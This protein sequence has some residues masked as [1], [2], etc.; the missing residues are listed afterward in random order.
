[1][2]APVSSKKPE[3]FTQP[4]F[5]RIGSNAVQSFLTDTAGVYV[6]KLPFIR[7]GLQLFEDTY[8]EGV[9][10]AAFY[11]TIPTVSDHVFAPLLSNAVDLKGK[12]L[13]SA[14]SVKD[15]VGTPI[16]KLG[17]VLN[18]LPEA[19]ARKLIGAK[20]GTV[21]GSLGVA[22]GFEY[23]IQHTKNWISADVF[24]AKN[25]T[26]VAGLEDRQNKL[27]E[28]QHDPV[29]KAKRRFKQVGAAVAGTTLG[30]LAVAKGVQNGVIPTTVAKNSLKWMDFGNVFDLSKPLQAALVGV[31]VVSYLDAARDKLE[32]KETATRLGMVVPY[33][34]VGKELSRNALAWGLERVKLPTEKVAIHQLKN[35]DGSRFSFFDAKPKNPFAAETFLNFDRVKSTIAP[36][37][38]KLAI[39]PESKQLINRL[40]K[41]IGTGQYLLSAVGMTAFVCLLTYSQTRQRYK[42]QQEALQNTL[43]AKA[44]VVKANNSPFGAFQ[45]HA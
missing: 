40:Y 22:A 37:V 28:G 17:P 1:M 18:A 29:A 35:A 7:S 6:P 11:F 3:Q 8:L 38:E 10:D 19:E 9:E 25:F 20:A 14:A 2:T 42:Q 41:G 12:G 23:L 45:Q 21:L 13:A 16:H 4:R 26:A 44:P 30:A 32:F 36:E 43:A 31:G 5:G 34:L 27:A 39:S 15:W 24:K 33:L